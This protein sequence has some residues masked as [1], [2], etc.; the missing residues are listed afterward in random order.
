VQAEQIDH[1]GRLVLSAL[2]V[3][4]G[5]A[6]AL[7]AAGRDSRAL[8]TIAYI[9]FGLELCFI[10]VVTIGTMLGTAGLFLASG[11]VLGVIAIVIIRVERRMRN[12]A[13]NQVGA[14]R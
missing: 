3:F 12:A 5:I 2:V 10:Y 13:T 14:A 1:A 8:R 9:G 7:Y 4:A 6:A 11:V